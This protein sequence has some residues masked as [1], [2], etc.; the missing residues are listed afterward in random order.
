MRVTS[1]VMEKY[2]F[3]YWEM[4][5]IYLKCMNTM[6]NISFHI[7]I[8]TTTPF[9]IDLPFPL[10]LF[11]LV[12]A[13]GLDWFLRIKPCPLSVIVV[14]YLNFSHNGL[15]Q[16]HYANF[17]KIWHTAPLKK[18]NVGKIKGHTGFFSEKIIKSY[19]RFVGI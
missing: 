14:V 18:S 2:I 1:V 9:F 19:W 3:L 7:R 15:L 5:L 11:K 8:V 17:N 4:R 12:S 16:N 6:T 10:I 13:K